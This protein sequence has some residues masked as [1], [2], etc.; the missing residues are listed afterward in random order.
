MRCWLLISYK[1]KIVCSKLVFEWHK[2]HFMIIFLEIIM[3]FCELMAPKITSGGNNCF[4]GTL[5]L[6]R[7]KLGG[8]DSLRRFKFLNKK[9]TNHYTIEICKCVQL[10]QIFTFDNDVS[11]DFHLIH[12]HWPFFSK[13]INS[14]FIHMCCAPIIFSI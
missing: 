9:P 5:P 1:K 3:W 12:I 2:L 7:M 11:T 13:F 4:Q 14:F 8:N 10:S 6:F